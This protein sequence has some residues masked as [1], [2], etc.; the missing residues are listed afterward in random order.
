[1]I[2]S[3][4]LLAAFLMDGVTRKGEGRNRKERGNVCMCVREKRVN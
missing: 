2:L 4:F 1:M 3:S